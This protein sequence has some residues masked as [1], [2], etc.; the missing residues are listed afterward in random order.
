[1]DRKAG[2]RARTGDPPGLLPPQGSCQLSYACMD[3]QTFSGSF[4][5]LRSASA[6]L[7]ARVCGVADSVVPP[8][9]SGRDPSGFHGGVRPRWRCL[10]DLNLRADQIRLPG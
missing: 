2:G 7:C 6:P 10:K 3:R 8:R 1:M 5:P 4:V 9:L